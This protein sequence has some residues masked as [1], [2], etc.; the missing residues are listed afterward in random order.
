MT[1]WVCSNCSHSFAIGEKNARETF[2]DGIHKRENTERKKVA[3]P[4]FFISSGV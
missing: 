3:Y 1:I 4:T 2:K